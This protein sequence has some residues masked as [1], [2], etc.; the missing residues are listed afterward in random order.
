MT[1][2]NEHRNVRKEIVM[3]NKKLSPQEEH[4]KS[5]AETVDMITA[6]DLVEQAVYAANAPKCC[7]PAEQAENMLGMLGAN[8]IDDGIYH[9]EEDHPGTEKQDTSSGRTL[10]I[11]DI[12]GK[13]VKLIPELVVI[14]VQDFMGEDQHNIGM[15]LYV[16]D[17]YGLE[18]YATLTVNFGEFIGA[19]DC[20]YIDT[21]NCYFAEQLLKQGVATDTGLTKQSGF[22]TY[23][24]WK[25]DEDFL[26]GVDEKLYSLYSEEYD[27]YME[28]MCPSEDDQSFGM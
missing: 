17:E 15:N 14:V 10:T 13:E 21:N 22:C 7:S 19:K 2:K 20:A 23:P 3:E 8:F 12:S 5:V 18:P 6:E 24:L 25:F 28:S 11:K 1:Q 26:K 16:E 4:E 27:A 9:S